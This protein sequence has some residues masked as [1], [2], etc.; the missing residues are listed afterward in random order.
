MKRRQRGDLIEALAHMEVNDPPYITTEVR[1]TPQFHSAT[2]RAR[3]SILE[4]RVF[5]TFTYNKRVYVVRVK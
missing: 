3:Q 5:K 2:L 4:G 1:T